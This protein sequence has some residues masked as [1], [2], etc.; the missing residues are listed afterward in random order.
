[1]TQLCLVPLAF[2]ALEVRAG[3]SSRT[4]TRWEPRGTQRLLCGFVP[5][6]CVVLGKSFNL[7]GF[8]HL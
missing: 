3:R 5:T 6:S 8:P 7:S 2:L 1:M 4:A